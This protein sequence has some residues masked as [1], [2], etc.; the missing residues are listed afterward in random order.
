MN[1]FSE[2]NKKLLIVDCYPTWCGPCEALNPC[3]KKLRDEVIDEFEKRVDV[4]LASQEKLEE[5]NN[6][7]FKVTCKPKLL[8]CLE[9]KIIHEINGPNIPELEENV[10][11]YVP[12]I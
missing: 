2:N 6:D 1:Y 4:V 9:G 3:Y 11:K 10:R 5:L 12:Y 7:K 8:L